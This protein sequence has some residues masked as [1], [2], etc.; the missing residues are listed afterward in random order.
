MFIC[1]MVPPTLPLILTPGS[2]SVAE[3]VLYGG[4]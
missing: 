3:K 2:F 4:S 1:S